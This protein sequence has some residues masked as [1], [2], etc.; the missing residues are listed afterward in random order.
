MSITYF[1]ALVGH[2]HQWQWVPMIESLCSMQ[3]KLRLQGR[4]TWSKSELTIVLKAAER[5]ELLVRATKWG[6]RIWRNRKNPVPAAV[7]SLP[8]DKCHTDTDSSSND[9]W[10]KRRRIS[11]KAKV[12]IYSI[13]PSTQCLLTVLKTSDNSVSW[14]VFS[15]KLCLVFSPAILPMTSCRRRAVSRDNMRHAD[16]TSS[17]IGSELVLQ[18]LLLVTQTL[19][20]AHI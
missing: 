11:P 2:K 19:A 12:T 16:V 4:Q 10:F 1:R 8:E 20:Y 13:I 6:R 5:R 17:S 3:S 14:S 9:A 7:T 18:E 15:I